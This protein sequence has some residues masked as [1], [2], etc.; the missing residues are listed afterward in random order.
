MCIFFIHSFI[1]TIPS[2]MIFY[3]FSYF[4]LQSFVFYFFSFDQIFILFIHFNCIFLLFCYFSCLFVFSILFL[5]SS[6]S[7]FLCPLFYYRCCLFLLCKFSLLFSSLKISL[8]FFIHKLSFLYQFSSSP[9]SSQPCFLSLAHPQTS[10]FF[11]CCVIHLAIAPMAPFLSTP[12]HPNQT[13]HTLSILI[14]I[15]RSCP[16]LKTLNTLR[17]KIMKITIK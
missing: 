13:Q 15:P 5:S 14:V 6:F 2:F 7:I 3:H 16:F 12:L 17:L 10:F 8:L 9:A 1:L 11:Y 4:F